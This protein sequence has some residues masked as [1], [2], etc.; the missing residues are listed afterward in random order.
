M[1]KKLS[2]KGD[3]RK[4]F[5]AVKILSIIVTVVI[6][7]GAYVL[8]IAFLQGKSLDSVI[9]DSSAGTKADLGVELVKAMY[10]FENPY[11]LDKNM[12]VVQKLV[13]ED[14][15]SDLTIDNE[16]RTLST[17]FKFK[18]ASVHVNVL[19]STDSYVLYS[20]DSEA[21]S[22]DRKFILIFSVNEEGVINEVKEMECYEYL[23]SIY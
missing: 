19:K 23:N 17:Y 5:T 22:A 12:L 15:F 1:S 9:S 8:A 2:V 13:T 21:I 20:L 7:F 4:I 6:T 14:V 10:D 3:K 16:Q 11:E 18:D